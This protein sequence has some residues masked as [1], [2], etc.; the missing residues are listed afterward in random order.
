MNRL[1]SLLV[2]GFCAAFYAIDAVA[3]E[4]II[5]SCFMTFACLEEKCSNIIPEPGSNFWFLRVHG[6]NSVSLNH[7]NYGDKTFTSG[8]RRISEYKEESTRVVVDN[9]TISIFQEM[10]TNYGRHVSTGATSTKE[11]VIDRINGTL[12]TEKR[13]SNGFSAQYK[14]KCEKSTRDV[15][16]KFLANTEKSKPQQKF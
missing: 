15:Y 5:L 2:T 4:E 6:E 13:M 10:Y 3:D 14:Y 16:E 11:I 8:S 1:L 9:M 12:V 7:N